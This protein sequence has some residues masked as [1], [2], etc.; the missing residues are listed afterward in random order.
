MKRAK[1]QL[2][3]STRDESQTNFVTRL[4]RPPQTFIRDHNDKAIVFKC[5]KT[6]WNNTGKLTKLYNYGSCEL[7]VVTVGQINPWFKCTGDKITPGT[8]LALYPKLSTTNLILIRSD[9]ATQKLNSGQPCKLH[10]WHYLNTTGQHFRMLWTALNQQAPCFYWLLSCN[11]K[12]YI[13]PYFSKIIISTLWGQV[14]NHT[15]AIA[16]ISTN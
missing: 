5:N 15:V 9:S 7:E 16:L 4:I 1:G 6:G 11:F 14:P 3:Y 12:R 10:L 13:L 8:N 2:K